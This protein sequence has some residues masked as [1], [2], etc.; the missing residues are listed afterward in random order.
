MRRRI[1]AIRLKDERFLGQNRYCAFKR[2]VAF[3]AGDPGTGRN[4]KPPPDPF[5]GSFRTSPKTVND[6]WVRSVCTENLVPNFKSTPL[7][8][9]DMQNDGFF[10][11]RIIQKL[12]APAKDSLL[13]LPLR[14]LIILLKM[15]AEFAPENRMHR[16]ESGR[17]I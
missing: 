16:Q 11:P 5:A 15:K 7:R 9:H 10:P 3:A 4:Q 1:R 13:A 8:T 12:E 17:L 14:R 2:L 6:S